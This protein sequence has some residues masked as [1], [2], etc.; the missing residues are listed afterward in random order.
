MSI[1]ILVGCK[2]IEY[3]RGYCLYDYRLLLSNGSLLKLRNRKSEGRKCS[4]PTCDRPYRALGYCKSHRQRVR[5]TGDPQEDKSL[6]PLWV[7][8]KDAN[9]YMVVKKN[10]VVIRIHRQVMEEQLGRVL[11]P[12]ENIHHINGIRDDNRIEN[13]ELW[14]SSQPSGQRVEDKVKWAMEI[15]KMYTDHQIT[16]RTV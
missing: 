6:T 16:V 11:L 15:I 2:K 8:H 12:G 7:P 5:N 10:N 9:G 4:L 3:C 14:S 13:L 1:C